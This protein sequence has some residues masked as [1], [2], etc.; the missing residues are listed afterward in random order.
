MVS[1]S[2]VSASTDVLLPHSSVIVSSIHLVRGSRSKNHPSIRLNILHNLQPFS[3]RIEGH[4]NDLANQFIGHKEPQ[5]R[6]NPLSEPCHNHRKPG[7][8]LLKQALAEL[9]DTPRLPPIPETA[10]P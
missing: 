4:L 10:T 3:G 5:R 6:R 8:A 1:A 7:F 2:V 9:P